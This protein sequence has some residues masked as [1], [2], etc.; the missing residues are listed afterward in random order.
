MKLAS[1]GEMKL[2]SKYIQ[3]EKEDNA[4]AKKRGRETTPQRPNDKTV[5][6]ARTETPQERMEG[7]IKDRLI[8]TQE[9]EEIPR[10]QWCPC[11]GVS[12]AADT[13]LRDVEHGRNHVEPKSRAI[14]CSLMSRNDRCEPRAKIIR[15]T[16]GIK[17]CLLLRTSDTVETG[18]EQP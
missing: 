17:D 2:S 16:G 14:P 18:E 7:E 5:E 8:F 3:L 13:F 11:T 15:K 6:T 10:H 12:V 1:V 4:E 9:G